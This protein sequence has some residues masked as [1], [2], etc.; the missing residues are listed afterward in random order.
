MRILYTE[1]NLK[2]EDSNILVYY[3]SKHDNVSRL[4]KLIEEAENRSRRQ[5]IHS[6]ELA[7]ASK[8]YEKSPHPLLPDPLGD[9]PLKVHALELQELPKMAKS[10][11]KPR[12]VLTPE[13]RRCVEKKGTVLLL[14]RSGTGVRSLVYLF[15]CQPLTYCVHRKPFVLRIGWDTIARPFW[16]GAAK[17]I[18]RQS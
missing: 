5:V 18:V 9:T 6:Q 16:M 11:W 1:R 17:K 2:K 12:L 4:L 10:H 3:V 14:G 15:P 8:L 7:V 13:E